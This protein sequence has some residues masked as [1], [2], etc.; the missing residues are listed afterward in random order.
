MVFHPLKA[1]KRD[2]TVRRIDLQ[3]A[4]CWP[5]QI[6]V[7]CQCLSTC[8]MLGGLPSAALSTA[9][10]EP[11]RLTSVEHVRRVVKGCDHIGKGP[12]RSVL[13]WQTRKG[14]RVCIL[15]RGSEGSDLF[16]RTNRVLNIKKVGMA[17][18]S[19]EARRVLASAKSKHRLQRI[20]EQ[21]SSI[22][23]TFEHRARND[24]LG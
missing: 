17:G 5:M 4:R 16:N 23:R 13:I 12:R 2:G 3:N 10:Q 22:E 15:P 11:A 7:R 19:Q 18:G 6:L 9:R 20:T 21:L 1:R 8:S 14:H 24:K